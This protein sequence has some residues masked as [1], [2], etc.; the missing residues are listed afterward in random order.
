VALVVA[1]T[2]SLELRRFDDLFFVKENMLP[3]KVS[4]PMDNRKL[5]RA[6]DQTSEESLEL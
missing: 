5:A 2:W 1:I 4:S 3:L 6:C